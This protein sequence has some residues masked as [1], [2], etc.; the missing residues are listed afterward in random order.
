MN[1]EPKISFVASCR[2]N[3][4]TLFFIERFAPNFDDAEIAVD[5]EGR[6]PAFPSEQE[7]RAEIARRFP[8]PRGRPLSNESS[9]AEIA[10]AMEDQYAG[11]LKLSYDLDAV[12]AWAKAPGPAGITPDLALKVWELCAQVG[13][14]PPVQRLDPMYLPAMH[15]N[16]VKYPDRRAHYELLLLGMKVSG[17]VI[18]AQESRQPPRWDLE[19]PEMAEIWPKT[20]YARLGDILGKGI[21]GFAQRV[22]ATS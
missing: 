21:A 20:D 7:A 3:G 2:L 5:A 12:R 18:L 14:A 19:W 11:V 16:I 4:T 13:D 10:A 9:M 6:I 8:L 17:L 15:E 1:P 22:R